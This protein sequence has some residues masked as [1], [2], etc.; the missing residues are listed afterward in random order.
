M[1][2]FNETKAGTAIINKAGGKGY[3]MSKKAELASLLVTSLLTDKAYETEEGICERLEDLYDDFKQTEEGRSF[4]NKAVYYA[5]DKFH[6]RSVSHLAS[7]LVAEGVVQNVY[8]ESEKKQLRSFF[9]KVVMRGDDLQE[10][11]AAYSQRE[12]AHKGANGKVQLPKVVQRGF[13]DAISNFD[14]YVLAKYKNT[15]K[16]YN[17]LNIVRMSHARKSNNNA[18]G[19]SKL[20]SGSLTNTSTWEAMQS[21]A[22]QTSGTEDEKRK[23]K[24]QAWRTFLDKGEKVEYFALLRNLRNIVEM[25]DAKLTKAACDLLTNRELIKK[26]KVLPF[27][28]LTAYKLFRYMDKRSVTKA[29]SQAMTIALDNVP[30]FD[31][32]TAILV[33]ISGS[34]S[35]SVGKDVSAAEIAAL[36]AAA[37]YRTN[38]SDIFCFNN[39]AYKVTP[40]P[41]DSLPTIAEQMYNRIGGGTAISAPFT[42]MTE[43]YDRVIILSDMQT[44]YDHPYCG[45]GAN[46]AYQHYCKKTDCHPSIFSFDLAGHGELAFPESNVCLLAGYSDHVFNLMNKLEEDKNFLVHEIEA[47]QF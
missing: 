36:F 9:N 13:S 38:D 10:I 20:V 1:A 44:W 29:L 40:N 28:F 30:T 19:L 27:R 17:M 14:E 45:M 5:R 37:L 43:K 11:T 3:L 23:A 35:V 34:M 33:D 22:G 6:L 4:F 32:K 42:Q 7:A 8:T 24:L 39:K 25:E 18:D 16:K 2:K 31:G 21:A 46:Q 15:S 12:G 41:E 26:S 47:V